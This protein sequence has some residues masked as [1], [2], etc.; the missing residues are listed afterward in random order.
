[1]E[2]GLEALVFLSQ[3]LEVDFESGLRESKKVKVVECLWDGSE[4]VGLF[5][6][7]EVVDCFNVCCTRQGHYQRLR[8]AQKFGVNC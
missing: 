6:Q 1:M 8:P 7:H 2:Y 3:S 5:A 4:G